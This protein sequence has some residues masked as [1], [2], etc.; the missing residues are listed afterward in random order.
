MYE[1][2]AKSNKSLLER[3]VGEASGQQESVAK[4]VKDGEVGARTAEA[5]A[6]DSPQPLA[7]GSDEFRHPAAS[8]CHRGGTPAAVRDA[9]R[10]ITPTRGNPV[11]DTIRLRLLSVRLRSAWIPLGLNCAFS[12]H[13]TRHY[14]RAFTVTTHTYS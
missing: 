6:C 10:A 7:G 12:P 5:P 1:Q 8:H 11:S 14:L 4:R 9:K 3:W 2:F 13:H